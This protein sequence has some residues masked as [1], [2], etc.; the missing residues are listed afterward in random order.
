MKY[1][2]HTY[3]QYCQ[4]QIIE[5]PA[6]ALWVDMGLGKTAITLSAIQELKYDR[7]DVCRV[8]VVA[9]KKVAEAT[10]QAEAQKW[11]HTRHLRISTVL[12]GEQKRIRAV[13]TPADIYV[14]N[15]DNI[16]WLVDYYRNAWPFDMVVLDEASSFKNHRSLRFKAL[17]SIRPHIRRIVELTGT[18]SPNSLIDLWAQIYLL[19][20]GQRLGKTVTGFRERY[21]NPDKR[22]ATRIFSYAPKDGADDTVKSLL[23]D[24]CISMK[25]A[26][27]LDLPDM[28]MDTIPVKLDQ[29]AQQAY[30]RLERDMLLRVDEQMIDAGNAAILSNKLLQLCNGAVYDDEHATAEIHTCKLE[31]LAELMEALDGQHALVFYNFKHDRDRILEYFKKS[32]LHIRVY[33]GTQ[34]EQDW[35]AGKIDMLLAHPASCA[36]G[37]NLQQGGHHAVWFGL[38]WGLELFLQANKRLHRQGQTEPVI[39]HQLVTQGG[40]DEDVVNALESKDATQESLLKSLKARI[41]KVKSL[42]G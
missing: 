28:V 22:D 24:I 18:P 26:D 3:Q 31:A 4:Q 11:D 2:P 34:D 8:L 14:I 12:G 13:N 23:S 36:F 20:Q 5:H 16:K 35:N 30:T 27:Y 19:D 33:A 39:I 17:R 38:P 41:Q 29:K 25:A 9:P 42:T 32:K 37:L 6:L 1:T 10:W 21:F 15:R 40:R 7:F